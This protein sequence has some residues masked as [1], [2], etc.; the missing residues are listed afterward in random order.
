MRVIRRQQSYIAVAVAIYAALWAAGRPVPIGRTLIY[1]LTL[2]NAL[3]LM[4]DRLGFLYNRK[5]FLSSWAIYLSLLLVVS[6]V[7]VT[8]INTLQ[9]PALGIPG[10]TLVGVPGKRMEVP[11]HG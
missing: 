4:Q 10:Q 3:D 6:I 5:K 11:L 8:A 1:T 9:F 7:A 2:C